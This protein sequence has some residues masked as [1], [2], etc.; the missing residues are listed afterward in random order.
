METISL[1]I[2]TMMTT[3]NSNDDYKEDEVLGKSIDMKGKWYR[4]EEEEE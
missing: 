2:A 3:T 1:T 4:E